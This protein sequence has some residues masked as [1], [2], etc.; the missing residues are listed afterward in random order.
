MGNASFA[1][2]AADAATVATWGY[3]LYGG[4][5]LPAT[6]TTAMLTQPAQENLAP[7]V[8]YG[9]GAQVFDG[10]ATDLA[11]GHLGDL[12]GYDSILVVIPARTLSI[13]VLTFTNGN[14]GRVQQIVRDL[15][16]ALA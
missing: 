5:I 6:V 1:G 9:L 3:Q 10:L 12:A 16:S 7:G 14:S 13:A 2:I 8:G 15:L 11:V 4:R